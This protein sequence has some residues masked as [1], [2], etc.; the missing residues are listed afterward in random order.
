[1]T[2]PAPADD[3]EQLMQDLN[4]S[5]L[6]AGTGGMDAKGAAT[7]G[8]SLAAINIPEGF[9]EG[10]RSLARFDVAGMLFA[11]DPRIVERIAAS[12]Y[13]AVLSTEATPTDMAKRLKIRDYLRAA[14][15]EHLLL[16]GMRS[17]MYGTAW[18]VA[19][20]GPASLHGGG[21][22][23]DSELEIAR[24][25][26]PCILFNCLK[27]RG[28]TTGQQGTAPGRLLP[29]DAKRLRVAILEARGFG[30]GEIA[31]QMSMKPRSISNLL[32]DIRERL[33]IERG[34]NITLLDLEYY[35]GRVDCGKALKADRS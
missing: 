3:F 25:R 20:R 21:A 12:H 2:S 15:F 6:F 22:F 11:A 33:G 17:A 14:G 13:E 30:A 24:Y 4:A 18:I 35:A 27:A 31:E 9:V 1:M 34:R 26:A 10:Y 5:A 7:I 8:D 23:T 32:T 16:A 19:Y 29:L 28:K